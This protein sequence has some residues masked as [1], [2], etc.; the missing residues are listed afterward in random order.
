MERKV[1]KA[2]LK[3]L[4]NRLTRLL[5]IRTQK[6]VNC[7]ST[8]SAEVSTSKER[9]VKIDP[10]KSRDYFDVH[11]LFTVEDLFKA[12]VHLGHTPK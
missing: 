5:S 2:W 12:R 6:F 1:I 9:S 11:K 4:S 8:S 7:Q 3:M 10:L